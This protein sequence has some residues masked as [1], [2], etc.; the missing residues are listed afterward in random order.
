MN[1]LKFPLHQRSAG[2][3]VQVTLSGTESDVFLVDPSNL[4]AME[5]GRQFSYHG[6][7][8]KK[9]PVRLVV[10]S[11]GVWTAIVV[12]G[13]NGRVRASVQTLAS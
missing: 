9:S 1:F 4:Q 13:K 5:S 8:F 6:G 10:P 2:T 7:H 3:V 12:P 11:N